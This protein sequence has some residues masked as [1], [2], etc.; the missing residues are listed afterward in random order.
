MSEIYDYTPNQP[1]LL[2]NLTQRT[3]ETS[4]R[5]FVSICASELQLD[6]AEREEELFLSHVPVKMSFSRQ[7]HISVPL[8][9]LKALFPYYDCA[10]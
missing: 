2:L 10:S 7:R 4:A 6:A 3:R 8:H 9:L 5:S 1:L